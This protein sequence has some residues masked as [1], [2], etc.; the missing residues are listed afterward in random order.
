MPYK[1]YPL[2]HDLNLFL[3]ITRTRE[4]DRLPIKLAATQLFKNKDPRIRNVKVEITST[5][6]NI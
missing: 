2:F 5:T 4:M 6:Y 1:G 3:L